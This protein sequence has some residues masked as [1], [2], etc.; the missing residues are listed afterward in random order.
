MATAIASLPG[1]II[2]GI[3]GLFDGLI[4]FLRTCFDLVVDAVNS[5]VTGVV[6]FFRDPIGSILDFFGAVVDIVGGIVDA[7]L[8]G[9]KSLLKAL[10]V[11]SDDFFSSK[12]DSLNSDLKDHVDTDTYVGIMDGLKSVRSARSI[13]NIE[14]DFFGQHF[15]AVDFGYI[16]AHQSTIHDWVRGFLFIFLVLYNINEVYSLIRKDTLFKGSQHS[17][18]GGKGDS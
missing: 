8:D 1:L 5:I 15:V 7:I 13:P 11:P 4:S 3:K 18:G 10:F 6:D 9:F 17:G 12:F 14:F 16:Q 2:D